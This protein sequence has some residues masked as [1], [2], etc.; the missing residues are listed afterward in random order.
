MLKIID[1]FND[2]LST[3]DKTAKSSEFE[4]FYKESRKPE[5]NLKDLNKLFLGKNDLQNSIIKTYGLRGFQFGNWVTNEDRINYLISMRLCFIDLQNV[6]KFKANN[7]GLSG[8]LGVALGS[9]GIAKASAHFEPH[10]RVINISRYKRADVMAKMYSIIDS[11]VTAKDFTKEYL[12]F[13]TGGIGSFAHEYG[14]FLD[15]CFC[16]F[17]EQNGRN[18]FLTGSKLIDPIK[19]IKYDTKK[20]PLHSLMNKIIETL[21]F[22]KKGELS[23][24]FR[25][26]K[27]ADG[28]R[29][30]YYQLRCEIWARLF[31]QYIQIKLAE[32][33]IYNIFLTKRKYSNSVYLTPTEIKPVIPLIDKLMIH[34]RSRT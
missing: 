34:F 17:Q 22:D 32:K 10:T 16:I 9:R 3:A 4:L 6:L 11:G 19:R 28:E 26:L 13:N 23:P 15:N 24:F 2:K 31:E 18:Y 21:I 12:W 27:E 14:H 1:T 25:R 8:T 30:V 5:P 33:K 7:L 20:M 29:K